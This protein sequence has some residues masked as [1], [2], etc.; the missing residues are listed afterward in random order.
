MK[1]QTITL[2]LPFIVAVSQS[3]PYESTYLRD[4]RSYIYKNKRSTCPI[5]YL[6]STRF[7]ARYLQGATSK[8]ISCGQTCCKKKQYSDDEQFAKRIRNGRKTKIGQFPWSVAIFKRSPIGWKFHCGGVLLSDNKIAT[9]AHCIPDET[10]NDIDNTL[11]VTIGEN[12]I[13]VDRETGL[14]KR[15]LHL[16]RDLSVDGSHI[17]VK[18]T[19]N[20]RGN[21]IGNIRGDDLAILQ[22][23]KS[24]NKPRI[25]IRSAKTWP[26]EPVCYGI[27]HGYTGTE[28]N[29]SSRLRFTR[30]ELDFSNSCIEISNGHMLCATGPEERTASCQ[31]D[32]G[33]PVVCRI[34]PGDECSSFFLAGIFSFKPISYNGYCNGNFSVLTNLLNNAIEEQTIQHSVFS[35]SKLDYFQQADENGD[36]EECTSVLDKYRHMLQ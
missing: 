23:A 4:F 16:L 21:K 15:R 5:G 9:S 26:R 35:A 27:G 13:H 33:S 6:P 29:I 11:R 28:P 20:L 31:M 2:V 12:N 1:L 19:L 30:V 36:N 14:R 10:T 17:L 25:C 3:F 24:V 32:S 7:T 8:C 18:P 34:D 22:L